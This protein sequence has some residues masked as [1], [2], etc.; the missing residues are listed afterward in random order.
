MR[1]LIS[2]HCCISNTAFLN[3]LKNPSPLLLL[4]S[5]KHASVKDEDEAMAGA[6]DRVEL[7]LGSDLAG[8]GET[9]KLIDL[10]LLMALTKLIVSTFK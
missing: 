10:F 8:Q 1:E 5:G 3:Y 2:S 7:C 6:E 9:L 4:I